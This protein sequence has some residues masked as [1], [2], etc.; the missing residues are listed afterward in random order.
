M[1]NKKNTLALK[2]LPKRKY[3][4]RKYAKKKVETTHPF[5][6]NNLE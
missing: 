4:K 1:K 2:K 5:R 6:N 3:V